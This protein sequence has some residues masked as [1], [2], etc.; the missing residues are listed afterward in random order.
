MYTPDQKSY[1]CHWH[2]G[3]LLH[4]RAGFH[5]HLVNHLSIPGTLGVRSTSPSMSL[6]SRT[7]WSWGVAFPPRSGIC[8]VQCGH[9]GR[10]LLW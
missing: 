9:P 3:T 1:R 8:A 7:T 10:H 6:M 5:I 4:A 2:K